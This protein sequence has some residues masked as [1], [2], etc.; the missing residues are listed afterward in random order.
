MKKSKNALS[1]KDYKESKT[2]KCEHLSIFY[3][4]SDHPALQD[5]SFKIIKPSFVLI[6]G[7][8]GSGKTT[9]LRALRGLGKEF[10]M[11]VKGNVYVKGTNILEKPPE[12]LGKITGIVFQRPLTQLFAQRV[13]EELQI[14]P[15][16]L[17]WSWEDIHRVEKE[18]A[19]EF[20]V[21]NFLN[22]NTREL[23]GGEQQKVVVAA[24]LM[25]KPN[26]LLLDEPGSF[27]D[28][29]SR[30]RLFAKLQKLVDM[31]I[32]IVM[33]SHRLEDEIKY[34]DY[35]LVLDDGILRM[36]GKP[37]D[38]MFAEDVEE[39]IPSRGFLKISKKL[40]KHGFI[41][42]KIFNASDLLTCLNKVKLN[43][44]EPDEDK[45]EELNPILQFKNLKV[46]YP[47]GVTALQN[48]TATIPRNKITVILGPNGSGKTTLA[49]ACLRQI[50][51]SHGQIFLNGVDINKI[52]RKELSP[53]VGFVSQD[54]RE[55]LF[56][57]T[58]FEEILD[59]AQSLNLPRPLKNTQEILELLDL[60]TLKDKAPEILSLG[61][62]RRLTLALAFVAKPQVLILDEPGLALDTES[63]DLL[64]KLLL[65][66][67]QRTSI[68]I[69]THDVDHFVPLSDY[70]I[71]LNKHGKL[72]SQGFP[73]D[74]L[75]KQKILQT[76]L[77]YPALYELWK[78][79]PN[80]RLWE[81]LTEKMINLYATANDN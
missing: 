55:M 46:E 69:L 7:P 57:E 39:I 80:L 68:V 22:K 24:N 11:R 17:N 54:P 29:S 47:N 3:S 15:M 42:K 44:E 53:V 79:F 35:L 71:L 2:L 67:K 1:F 36:Q 8:N 48:L 74:I 60:T 10:G 19:E 45:K 6:C 40:W 21:K 26:I 23:S 75:T 16:L 38:I 20:G 59:T 62:Q 70:V 5:I 64:L 63:V 65:Q 13:E 27:L 50:K 14:G 49:K 41:P 72:V 56:C 33:T 81:N 12:I 31:G 66:L 77:K 18:I 51:I 61:Q 76:D 37:T 4:N 32:T 28:S 43:L 73:F 9:L 30:D 58:L 34:A 52:T 78:A 25:L